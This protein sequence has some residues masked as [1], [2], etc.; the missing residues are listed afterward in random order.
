MNKFDK[1]DMRSNKKSYKNFNRQEIALIKIEDKINDL[2]R[3]ESFLWNTFYKKYNTN[4]NVG[5]L[6]NDDESGKINNIINDR[7][8]LEKKR[9]YIENKYNLTSDAVVKN[10]NRY[11]QGRF[12]GGSF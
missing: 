7:E 5:K 9:N 10:F 1:I 4:K 11:N 2:L 3:Y 6:L 8:K 12:Y